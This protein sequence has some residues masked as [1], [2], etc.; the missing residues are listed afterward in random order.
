LVLF[1]WFLCF[2]FSSSSFASIVLNY[3][4]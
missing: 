1:C 3:K 4:P 2:F